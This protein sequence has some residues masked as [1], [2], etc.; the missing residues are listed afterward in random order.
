MDC[1]DEEWIRSGPKRGI[2]RK[3][4]IGPNHPRYAEFC[5]F[6]ETVKVKYITP[7]ESSRIESSLQQQQKHIEHADQVDFTA[8]EADLEWGS[9]LHFDEFDD[10][11]VA[12]TARS[13][14]RPTRMAA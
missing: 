8:L 14:D 1:L 7:R 10:A 5:R 6:A 2:S 12:S 3:W 9:E 11:E 4:T 13:R